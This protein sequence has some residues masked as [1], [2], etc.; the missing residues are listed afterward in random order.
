MILS[1]AICES[2]NSCIISIRQNSKTL[3]WEVVG[4][5]VSRPEDTIVG[6]PCLERVAIEAVDKHNVD[7]RIG[8]TE[9]LSQANIRYGCCKTRAHGEQSMEM[10]KG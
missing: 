4:K 6:S 5:K 10:R 2:T 7:V 8:S 3:I 9:D 1:N